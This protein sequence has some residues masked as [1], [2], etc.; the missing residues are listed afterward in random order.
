MKL[1]QCYPMDFYSP[2]MIGYENDSSSQ[3]EMILSSSDNEEYIRENL[4][5]DDMITTSEKIH[6]VKIQ[7]Y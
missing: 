6:Y 4:Q 1:D 7:H 3:N 5:N 2:N